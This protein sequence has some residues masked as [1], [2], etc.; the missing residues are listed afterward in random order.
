MNRAGQLCGC[1]SP[2][3]KQGFTLIELLVVT[4]VIAILAA[5]LLPALSRAKLVADSTSCRSNLRQLLIGLSLY[6]QQERVYPNNILPSDP[7]SGELGPFLRVPPPI[8]NY[9]Q[10]NHGTWSYL[11]PRTSVW[12]CP[13]YNRVRGWVGGG[14]SYGYNEVGSPD[15]DQSSLGLGGYLVDNGAAVSLVSIRETQVLFPSDMIAIGDEI[16]ITDSERGDMPVLGWSGLD[17]FG[18]ANLTFYKSIIPGVPAKD[19]AV[20]AMKQRHGGRWSIG[21][22]DGHVEYVRPGSVFD[23]IDPFKLRRWNNDHQPHGVDW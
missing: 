18:S 22:C 13:G 10:V 17:A 9:T 19:S 6:V 14:V 8:N 1:R 21:F 5:L 7:N 4:A 2:A 3:Q 23:R 12:V 15:N 11:G 16:L 20:R